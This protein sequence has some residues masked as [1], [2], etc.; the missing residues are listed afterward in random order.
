MQISGLIE[1][2]STPVFR[3]FFVLIKSIWC[4]IC[5]TIVKKVVSC[6][7]FR[8]WIHSVSICNELLEFSPI[9][10]K[11]CGIHTQSTYYLDVLCVFPDLLIQSLKRKAVANCPIHPY[12]LQIVIWLSVMHYYQLIQQKPEWDCRK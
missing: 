7:K 11:T 4:P 10:A 8:D 12:S 2:L 6:H 1:K 3:H 5:S 9:S